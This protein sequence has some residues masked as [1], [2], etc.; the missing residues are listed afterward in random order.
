MD[1]EEILYTH[2]HTHIHTGLLLSHQKE[3][4]LAICNDVGGARVHYA[5]Q[6]K[7]EKDKCHMSS[8]ICGI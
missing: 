4:N 7:S 2:I 8:L 3:W 1:K 5:K 6:N